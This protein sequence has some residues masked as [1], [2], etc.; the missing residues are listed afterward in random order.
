MAG[1]ALGLQVDAAGCLFG[2]LDLETDVLEPAI[3]D[4]CS[5]FVDRKLTTS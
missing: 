4:A 1:S 2:S 3:E 5:A